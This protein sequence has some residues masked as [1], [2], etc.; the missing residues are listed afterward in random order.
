MT[1]PSRQ[2]AAFEVIEADL[3]F[4]FLVLLLDRPPLM[5]E[6]APA[7]AARRWPGG[8][9]GSSER[10]RRPPVPVRTATRLRA[11]AVVPSRQSCAGVTRT[12]QKRA[13]HGRFVPLRHD[14]SRHWRGVWVAAHARASTVCVSGGKRRRVRG[15]PFARQRRRRFERGRSQEHLE[16]G[17]DAQGVGQLGAMQ[18]AAQR[19]VVAELGIAD[20]GRDR[21]PGRAHLAQQRQGQLPFRRE[22]HGRRESGP[23][24]AGAA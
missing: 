9:P 22:S 2:A 18:R 11:R 4:E 17:R 8:R 19:G 16:I 15:R 7:R 14:T 23:A 12:A 6:A 24:S 21:E 5:R 20:H 13:R 10:G 3:V 1:L